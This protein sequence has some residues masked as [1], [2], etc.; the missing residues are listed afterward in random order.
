MKVFRFLESRVH[1]LFIT[2]PCFFKNFCSPVHPDCTRVA[3][4]FVI[5]III[6]FAFN[7]KTKKREREGLKFQVC[8]PKVSV[9]T[10]FP[11][12]ESI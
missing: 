3:P 5:I 10:L 6:M 1:A 12:P 11:A 8:V 2:F 9:K 7:K 4:D